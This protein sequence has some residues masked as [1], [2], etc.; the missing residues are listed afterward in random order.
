MSACWRTSLV[1]RILAS[2]APLP[3]LGWMVADIVAGRESV[4]IVVVGLVTSALLVW[5][6]A[7]RP[8]IQLTSHDVFVRNPVRSKRIPLTDWGCCTSR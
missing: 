6:F 5:L 1:G 3:L 7:Y 2:V 4:W 8:Y